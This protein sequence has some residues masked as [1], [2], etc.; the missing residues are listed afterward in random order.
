MTFLFLTLA[1]AT[2]EDDALPFLE[3]AKIALEQNRLPAAAAALEDALAID[4]ENIDALEASALVALHRGQPE[5][6]IALL[7]RLLK[8]DRHN[9]DAMVTLARAL[10]HTGNPEKAQDVLD[11]VLARH[12]S[13]LAALEL[14]RDVRSQPAPKQ[15]SWN[16]TLRVGM[17]LV[18][19]SN[20]S[21]DPDLV[22]D[23]PNRQATLAN[24]DAG[25]ALDY[26][27]AL[28]VIARLNSFMPLHKQDAVGDLTPTT[29]T[30]GVMGR[31]NSG[32]LQT[33]IDLRYE[34]LF[35][36]LFDNHLQRTLNPNIWAA[37]PLGKMNR[38]RLLVGA[39]LR[40][41]EEDF[42]PDSNTTIKGAVRDDIS[43]DK[44]SLTLDVTG[45]YNTGGSDPTDALNLRSNF[46][47]VGGTIL[48]QYPLSDN[49]HGFLLVTA[50]GREFEQGLKESTYNG[51]L[52]LTLSLESIQLFAE[53]GYATNLSSKVR[54]YDRH[55]ATVGVRATY[56]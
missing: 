10:W 36:N 2:A 46:K 18:Y 19:D 43:L 51:V 45:R 20:V 41:P 26:R 8:L 27:E 42:A 47:E 9:D 30:A 29:L 3:E 49:L 25:V 17:A 22:P 13:Y 38:L 52:G 11:S 28:T 53:Y 32:R 40:L 31:L 44:L 12:P 4:S 50:Q 48:A 5:Q 39:D 16:P 6:A 14:Q 55:Q 15:S 23:V 37:Y 34:E 56:N 35:T 7:E 21:L 24:I 33:A 1:L 54:S